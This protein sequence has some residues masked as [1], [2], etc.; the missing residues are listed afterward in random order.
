MDSDCEGD[1]V[2]LVGAIEGA[3]SRVRGAEG[4]ARAKAAPTCQR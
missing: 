1:A 2:C 4:L 3:V